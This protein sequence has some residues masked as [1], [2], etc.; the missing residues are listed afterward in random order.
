MILLHGVARLEGAIILVAPK[1]DEGGSIAL[2]T[3]RTVGG[4][5]PYRNIDG[6]ICRPAERSYNAESEPRGHKIVILR[7]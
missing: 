6:A 4:N 1:S 2:R 7:V 3:P 5:R